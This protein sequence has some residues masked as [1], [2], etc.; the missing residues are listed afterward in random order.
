MTAAKRTIRLALACMG[1][2]GATGVALAQAELSLRLHRDFGFAWGSQIQGSFT[3]EAEATGE[4]AR[5]AF[6]L[7][8]D[9]MGE[10]LQAPYVVSLHTGDYGLGWHTLSAEGVTPD[11]RRLVSN[12]LRLEFV[13]SDAGPKFM[14]RIVVPLLGGVA[15]LM[16]V[17]A[18]VPTIGGRAAFHVGRYGSAGGTV[19][20]RCNLPF[21]RHLLSPNLGFGKLERCPHCG[22]WSI[23]A[24]AARQA[25]A[26]AEARFSSSGVAANPASDDDRLHQQIEDSRF[27]D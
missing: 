9:L 8:D 19:C 4:L 15:V 14:V 13:P 26:E 1:L 25:L 3:I 22:R 23:V 21:G 27:L 2:L 5:V 20:P 18:V 7:D 12:E 6:W 11:G 24:R 16:L 10:A 17:F